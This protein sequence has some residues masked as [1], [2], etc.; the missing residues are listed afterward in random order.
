[1]RWRPADHLD[2]QLG[3]LWAAVAALSVLCY[4]LGR[5]VATV[6]P[7]CPLRTLA[8]VACPTC[9]STRAI[10]A[11]GDGRLG[12]AL[13]WNPLVTSAACLF[14]A[15]GLVA[16]WWNLGVGRL[17]RTPDLARPVPRIVAIGILLVNWVWL[18]ARGV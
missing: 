5:A 13:A 4:P 11:L 6:V 12:E 3:V 1:M 10:L 8:G 2:R 15:G 16:P 14:L 9:G 18:V 17:P 7:A